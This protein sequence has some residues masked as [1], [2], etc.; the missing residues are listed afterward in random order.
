M[1]RAVVHKAS[2]THQIPWLEERF[3]VRKQLIDR[4]NSASSGFARLNSLYTNKSHPVLF[5]IPITDAIEEKKHIDEKKNTRTLCKPFSLKYAISPTSR[6]LLRKPQR[7]RKP[8]DKKWVD[9]FPRCN[10][11]GCPRHIHANCTACDQKDMCYGCSYSD[12]DKFHTPGHDLCGR[13]TIDTNYKDWCIC[14]VRRAALYFRQKDKNDIEMP[15]RIKREFGFFCSEVMS[16]VGSTA[17]VTRVKVKLLLFDVCKALENHDKHMKLP[18]FD[19]YVKHTKTVPSMKGLCREC[20]QQRGLC[21]KPQCVSTRALVGV[22]IMCMDIGI[23]CE[24]GDCTMDRKKKH[25]KN[26]IHELPFLPLRCYKGALTGASVAARPSVER[27]CPN[28]RCETCHRVGYP[29]PRKEC[30]NRLAWIHTRSADAHCCKCECGLGGVPTCAFAV[31][32]HTRRGFLIR[33]DTTT[34]TTTTKTTRTY[35]DVGDAIHHA[36]RSKPMSLREMYGKNLAEYDPVLPGYLSETLGEQGGKPDKDDIDDLDDAGESREFDDG[37]DNEGEDG[38]DKQDYV[39]NRY[40]SVY[41]DRSTRQAKHL[42]NNSLESKIRL[43]DKGIPTFVYPDFK[44]CRHVVL[45]GNGIDRA[46]LEGRA[47]HAQL[48]LTRRSQ[49]KAMFNLYRTLFSLDFDARIRNLDHDGGLYYDQAMR[50]KELR[51]LGWDMT[52]SIENMK[53][54]FA[55][56]NAVKVESVKAFIVLDN[57]KASTVS[58]SNLEFNQEDLIARMMPPGLATP[59]FGL[60]VFGWTSEIEHPVTKAPFPFFFPHV[61]YAIASN[62]ST[63]F[64]ITAA[65]EASMANAFEA[66]RIEAMESERRKGK[67]GIK[68]YQQAVMRRKYFPYPTGVVRKDF[69]LKLGELVLLYSL[70]LFLEYDSETRKVSKKQDLVI[71]AEIDDEESSYDASDEGKSSQDGGVLPGARKT[72]ARNPV[73]GRWN[74]ISTC[75]RYA[76]AFFYLACSLSSSCMPLQRLRAFIAQTPLKT[77]TIAAAI[78][79]VRLGCSIARAFNDA[80]GGEVVARG[81]ADLI[82]RMFPRSA[83]IMSL[84]RYTWDTIKRQLVDY[85]SFDYSNDPADVEW[86]LIQ[87]TDFTQC[88]FAMR[89]QLTCE[90]L[91]TIVENRDGKRDDERSQK[92]RDFINKSTKRSDFAYLVIAL[93]NSCVPTKPRPGSILTAARLN[94]IMYKGE[95]H[96]TGNGVLQQ[97]RENGFSSEELLS[98]TDD[99]L[100]AAERY[101]KLT[102]TSAPVGTRNLAKT[103]FNSLFKEYEG[104]RDKIMS[105]A[106]LKSSASLHP[107][108]LP[109]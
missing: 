35:V 13:Q 50:L 8:S 20:D 40:D 34:T 74:K 2:V 3:P 1:G 24:L 14:C 75:L 106:C 61:K 66:Q 27:E 12:R 93:F 98:E 16:F 26:E 33:E 9:L 89:L 55:R 47:E 45:L 83:L 44:N 109:E 51:G 78:R 28:T 62:C 18:V 92:V 99:I 95:E 101:L 91:F 17:D 52:T 97:L 94:R 32:D 102:A 57:R 48:K 100:S 104:R 54:D 49:V 79:D 31:E 7:V 107:V 90:Y 71:E 81:K 59:P 36:K 41:K 84:L 67:E 88:R 38:N 64:V 58:I 86:K 105:I 30:A 6:P 72:R 60:D 23:P 29:C 22:C 77:G 46:L 82:A 15:E 11:P 4:E 21:L 53:K 43:C 69:E 70:S 39:G 56:A 37:D 80:K 73:I 25:R 19:Q 87:G 42:P 63:L 68:A 85:Y 103:R 108:L 5:R 76:Y 65:L 10:F 96:H